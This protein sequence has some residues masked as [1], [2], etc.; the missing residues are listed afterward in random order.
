MTQVAV[1]DI[2]D[3]YKNLFSST[4]ECLKAQCRNKMASEGLTS[5]LCDEIFEDIVF[6]FNGI[7]TGHLQEKYFQES[8][9]I[10]V[11]Y[12]PS[13]VS[14]INLL[15]IFEFLSKWL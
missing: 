4:V 12:S 2:V 15:Y 9:G 6:P 10:I 13:V 14:C 8:L 7:E 1:D 11:R 3:G 5:T